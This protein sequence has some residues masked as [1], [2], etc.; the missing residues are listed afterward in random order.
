MLSLS[1]G[2]QSQ[3]LAPLSYLDSG[4][5]TSIIHIILLF[6]LIVSL[7]LFL[8]PMLKAN[9]LQLKKQPLSDKV[10]PMLL[11]GVSAALFIANIV[12]IIVFCDDYSELAGLSVWGIFYIIFTVLANAHL[13]FCWWKSQ[14]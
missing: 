1:Y 5:N 12:T 2:K 9:G 10:L 13:G 6:A 11:L 14:K 3:W 4:D 7:G 8:L